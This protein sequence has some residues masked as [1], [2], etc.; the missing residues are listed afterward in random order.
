[1]DMGSGG[2]RWVLAELGVDVGRIVVDDIVECGAV[3]S[4]NIGGGQKIDRDIGIGRDPT[5]VH[6]DETSPAVGI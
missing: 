3:A 1:M 2:Y 5:L 6:V 4:S